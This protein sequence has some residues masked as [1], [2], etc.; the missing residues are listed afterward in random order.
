M[1]LEDITATKGKLFMIPRVIRFLETESG[2][3]I[4]EGGGRMSSDYLFNGDSFRFRKESEKVQEVDGDDSWMT[5][6]M[7]LMPLNCTLKNGCSG[8]KKV[9]F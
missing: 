5:A 8:K 3:V 2:M 1:N 6:R 7:C 4:A 9:F